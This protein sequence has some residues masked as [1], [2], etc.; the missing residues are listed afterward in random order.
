[1]QATQKNSEGCPSNEVFAA[2]V[3]SAWD[4]NW[5]PFNC[6]CSRVRL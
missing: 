6:F 4:E 3:T 1:L 2:A 5:R